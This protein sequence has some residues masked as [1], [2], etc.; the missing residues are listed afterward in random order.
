ML[1]VR[2]GYEVEHLQIKQGQAN[3]QCNSALTVDHDMGCASK[4]RS[5][6]RGT[7]DSLPSSA[8]PWLEVSAARS[9][10]GQE[11]NSQN[12]DRGSPDFVCNKFVFTEVSV[13]AARGNA[14]RQHLMTKSL[15]LAKVRE[16]QKRSE[17]DDRAISVTRR[18][19]SHWCSKLEV[20]LGTRPSSFSRQLPRP[21]VPTTGQSSPR[22]TTPTSS[23]T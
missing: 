14:S 15:V 2:L 10:W 23:T 20:A 21:T 16:K 5:Y 18:T 11:A 12:T 13:I 9:R 3:C 1:A 19:S 22:N 8:K 4:D 6:T 17:N 7:T